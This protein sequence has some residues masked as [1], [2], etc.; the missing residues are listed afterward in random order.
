MHQKNRIKKI[1]NIA[2]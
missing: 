2:P 1:Y